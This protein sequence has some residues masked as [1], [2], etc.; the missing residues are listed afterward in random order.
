VLVD[1]D[2]QASS[3]PDPHDQQLFPLLDPPHLRLIEAA[4]SGRVYRK[5]E[6]VFGHGVR[7]APFVVLTQGRLEFYDRGPEGDQFINDLLPGTFVGDLSIFTGDP[8]VA[9]CRAGTESCVLTLD[10]GTLRELTAHHPDLG[11]LLL[12]TM[13]LR[14]EWLEGRN[15]GQARL[16]GSRLSRDTFTIRDLLSRNLIPHRWIDTDLAG[17]DRTA[18]E[19]LG[20][21]SADAP[22]LVQGTT[23]LRRTTSESFG[24]RTGP[25]GGAAGP[26]IRGHP[27][28]R[29]HRHRRPHARPG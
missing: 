10:R 4:A 28:Q 21:T 22:V 24:Q 25:A 7:D 2:V 14:R 27:L 17:P 13:M 9:E 1:P 20:L 16:L 3:A 11:D 6:V 8:T 5:G 26:A 23:V 15:F 19:A 12:G 18:I 29:P